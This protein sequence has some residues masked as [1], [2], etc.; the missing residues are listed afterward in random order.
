MKASP[1]ADSIVEQNVPMVVRMGKCECCKKP[2]MSA[3]VPGQGITP[4]LHM[5]TQSE[6]CDVTRG[7]IDAM[8]GLDGGS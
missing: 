5:I 3:D 2:I 4:W 8:E 1:E 7:D 6:D